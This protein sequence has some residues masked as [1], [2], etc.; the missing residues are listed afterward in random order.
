[1]NINYNN[2]GFTFMDLRKMDMLQNQ[3]NL[4]EGKEDVALVDMIARDVSQISE[5]PVRTAVN[6][7]E[8][9]G[10]M[11]MEGIRGQGD[12]V[13]RTENMPRVYNEILENQMLHIKDIL[14]FAAID[15][16]KIKM[17]YNSYL[18]NRFLDLYDQPIPFEL[19]HALK[20]L[21]IPEAKADY[22][23]RYI[24]Q[25][26]LDGR[27]PVWARGLQLACYGWEMDYKS[28]ES[29]NYAI[30]AEDPEIIEAGHAE[31]AAEMAKVY[32]WR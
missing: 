6:A 8:H 23:P 19:N 14:S 12:T 24:S 1:M 20:D 31:W 10:G 27:A 7:P 21:D 9:F 18:I 26:E 16:D 11:R 25:F 4:C 3:L 29:I 15:P 17:E 32:E 28:K 22:R 13:C 5:V 2:K 30:M